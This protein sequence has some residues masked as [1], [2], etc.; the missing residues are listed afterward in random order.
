M[1]LAER[2]VEQREI[3]L[4]NKKRVGE[5]SENKRARATIRQDHQTA[6]TKE[7]PNQ[8]KP[9]K[10]QKKPTLETARCSRLNLESLTRALPSK[11]G[12]GASED[13]ALGE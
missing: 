10:P 6:V 11:T 7:K 1:G 3:V 5:R 4:K 2:D 8:T 13:C 12:C 9:K